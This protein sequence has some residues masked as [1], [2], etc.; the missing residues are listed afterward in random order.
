MNRYRRMS[1]F[2]LIELLVVVAVI[3]VLMSIMMPSLAGARKLAR[4]AVCAS[5]LR[6][7]AQAMNVYAADWE[8]AILGNSHTSGSGL[9]NGT[10]T[11]FAPGISV[12]SNVPNVLQGND[13]MSPTAQMMGFQF[14]TGGGANDR[15]D[16]FMAFQTY[17]PFICPENQW[18]STTYTGGGGPNFPIH[19]V[20]SYNAA[21]C[22]QNVNIKGSSISSFQG[23]FAIPSGWI[24]LPDSYRPN[25][26]RVGNPSQKVYMADGGRWF[27]GGSNYLAMDDDGG[28]SSTSVGGLDQDYGP[29]DNNT[30]AYA[31]GTKGDGRVVSMRH[32][33]PIPFGKLSAYKF[34][35]AFF[36]GHV[37]TMNGLDGADP[38]LWMPSGSSFGVSE[39][40]TQADWR[41]KYLING[42]P[43]SIR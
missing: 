32:G 29:W 25:V 26:N 16:R 13:W 27:S 23:Q 40:T 33:S 24:Q 6:A 14:N 2:T 3:A 12:S 21:A 34:N 37:E 11:S 1:G 42:T 39:V 9:Y 8:G 31:K 20:I 28:L 18:V 36:D 41:A 7:I 4:T 5:N 15:I 43:P 30:R 19:R 35:L 10:Y 38:S 22:F 17:K